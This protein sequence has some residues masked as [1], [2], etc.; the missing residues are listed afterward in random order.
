[1]AKTNKNGIPVSAINCFLPTEVPN[2]RLTQFMNFVF[3][4]FW[5]E[6]TGV[7]RNFGT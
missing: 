7:K 5:F 2:V 4:V 6:L 1:V 3:S